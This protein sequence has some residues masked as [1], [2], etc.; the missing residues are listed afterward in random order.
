MAN[1]LS[2]KDFA[3]FLVRTETLKGPDYMSRAASVC[4]DDFLPGIT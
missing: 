1:S 3:A 2:E 4:R